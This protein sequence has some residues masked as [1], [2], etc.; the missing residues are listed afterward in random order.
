MKQQCHKKVLILLLFLSLNLINAGNPI[1]DYEAN[2]D[3]VEEFLVIELY[4]QPVE[5]QYKQ[6]L[7]QK[8]KTFNISVNFVCNGIPVHFHPIVLALIFE[9]YDLIQA[10]TQKSDRV[11]FNP[12]FQDRNG[13]TLLHLFLGLGLSKYL[14]PLLNYKELQFDVPNR[15]K[16]TPLMVAIAQEDDQW[17]NMLLHEGANKYA[18]DLSGK[19]VKEYMKEYLSP[20][21]VAYY[22]PPKKRSISIVSSEHFLQE[23]AKRTKKIKRQF[24]NQHPLIMETTV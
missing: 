15:K 6:M 10:I 2:Q 14:I 24:V 8:I 7:L 1:I 4:H 18:M 9:N 22:F 19:S 3:A 17:I 5:E 21:D 16:V 20:E 12:N 13:N 23:E 11:P